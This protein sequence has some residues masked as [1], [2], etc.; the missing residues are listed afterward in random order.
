MAQRKKFSRNL[1]P[2]LDVDVTMLTAPDDLS[3]DDLEE[4]SLLYPE[5]FITVRL[6]D[7][8]DVRTSH[9]MCTAVLK[10]T[11]E[12]N[13]ELSRV[14]RDEFATDKATS[15]SV[16]ACSVMEKGIRKVLEMTKEY[17]AVALASKK[18]G[19]PRTQRLDQI[20]DELEK[21]CPVDNID[22]FLDHLFKEERE[23]RRANIGMFNFH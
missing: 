2:A 9:L 14:V 20:I 4:I 12:E 8:L 17:R 6:S 15:L 16:R 22:T 21:V 7:Y 23:Q 13:A 5:E 3:N 10:V 18:G 1:V 19:R 11:R